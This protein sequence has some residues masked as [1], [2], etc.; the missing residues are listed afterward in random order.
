MAAKSLEER[1][2]ECVR[3]E[4]NRVGQ[5]NTQNL[6]ERTRQLINSSA[7]SAARAIHSV[8]NSENSGSNQRQQKR[9]APKPT[10]PGHNLRFTKKPK[11]GN[12]SK[13]K[14]KVVTKSVYLLDC[15][16]GTDLKES[17]EY[18]L[19][20]DMIVV[21]GQLDLS[22]DQTEE[23]IRDELQALF[24]SSMP[25][26]SKHDF[27]FVRRD[28]N[29]IS[30]PVVKEDYKW[31]FSHVKHLCGTGRLYVRLNTP[32]GN[33]TRAEKPDDDIT[34]VEDLTENE[35]GTETPL[36]SLVPSALQLLSRSSN[37]PSTSSMPSTSSVPGLSSSVPGISDCLIPQPSTSGSYGTES[38][39]QQLTGMFPKQPE[40]TIKTVLDRVNTFDD[41]I[42]ALLQLGSQ[43]DNGMV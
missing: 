13:G 14:S 11:T 29:T 28:R 6:V 16:D 32:R 2:R 5:G 41:A 19:V 43:D 15:L 22:S 10:V 23:D 36:T 42:E 25:S 26:V 21:K 4:L 35:E 39:L 24:K 31:D 17:D 18:V 34:E 7:S 30:K 38:P 8:I 37:I 27:D 9:P 20:D 40:S 12:S 3:E 1:V 33:L